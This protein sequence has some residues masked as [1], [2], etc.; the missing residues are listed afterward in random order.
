[1]PSPPFGNVDWLFR[2]YK[3]SVAYPERVSERT[4][5]DY[6]RIMLLL[7]DWRTKKGDRIGDRPIKPM[8]PVAADKLY[9]LIVEG[10]PRQGLKLIALCRRAWNV[11]YRLHPDQ[12]DRDVPNPWFGVTKKRKAPPAESRLKAG[13]SWSCAMDSSHGVCDQ[14]ARKSLQYCSPGAT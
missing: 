10:R 6:E 11:V 7:A 3:L 14:A 2:E 4:R 9:A 5:G 12:F 13:A 8:T 1:M